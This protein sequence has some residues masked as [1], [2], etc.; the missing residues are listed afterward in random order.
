[1][2]PPLTKS[3]DPGPT[4]PRLVYRKRPS[5]VNQPRKARLTSTARNLGVASCLP[6]T[7]I[8]FSRPVSVPLRSSSPSAIRFPS[9]ASTHQEPGTDSCLFRVPLRRIFDVVIPVHTGSSPSMFGTLVMA[10]RPPPAA[11]DQSQP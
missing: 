5:L 2:P 8:T 11:V 9:V 3:L 10:T 1:M 7:L 6:F 4:T